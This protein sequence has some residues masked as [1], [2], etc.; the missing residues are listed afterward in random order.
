MSLYERLKRQMIAGM[1]AIVFAW[2]ALQ[3]DESE[4]LREIR[5]LQDRAKR[6]KRSELDRAREEAR[7]KLEAGQL[8]GNAWEVEA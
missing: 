1:A 6:R 7:A 5:A 3:S 4:R 8:W 2:R